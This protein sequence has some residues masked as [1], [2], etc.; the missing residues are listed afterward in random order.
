LTKG[1]GEK[2]HEPSQITS[3]TNLHCAYF[4]CFARLALD[5]TLNMTTMKQ[6][7]KSR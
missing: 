6:M 3:K 5:S 1:Y 2:S 7:K 4:H